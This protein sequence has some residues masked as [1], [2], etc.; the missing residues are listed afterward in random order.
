MAV[1]RKAIEAALAAIERLGTG[2]Q[3][4]APDAMLTDV[5]LAIEAGVSRATLARSDAIMTA[6]RQRKH[7][8][9]KLAAVQL[10]NSVAA[11]HARLRDQ[12]L[13]AMARLDAASLR[14]M[15]DE[16]L[17]EWEGI[18]QRSEP[19]F[20]MGMRERRGIDLNALIAKIYAMTIA[21]RERDKTIA[22]LNDR[23]NKLVNRIEV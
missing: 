17:C 21:I 10:A 22:E 5:N 13:L 18:K 7:E 11:S 3:L 14:R 23:L 9:A 8:S 19:E 6:W 12:D 1:K 2:T 20:A 16:F 4:I 15:P